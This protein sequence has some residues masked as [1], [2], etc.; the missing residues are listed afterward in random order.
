MGSER[1]P[2]LRILS[3]SI[4]LR[5]G[6]IEYSQHTLVR[7]NE[8]GQAAVEIAEHGLLRV[9]AGMLRVSVQA[10]LR[11]GQLA[12]LTLNL[13]AKFPEIANEGMKR[14]GV[15]HE[16]LDG[17]RSDFDSGLWP[18]ANSAMCDAMTPA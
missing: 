6:I 2:L 4:C 12:Q 15:C 3:Q 14:L 7:A 10:L 13:G 9:R 18:P 11:L 5:H 1:A 16:G 8:H 17:K